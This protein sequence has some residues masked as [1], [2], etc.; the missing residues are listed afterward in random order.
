VFLVLFGTVLAGT[1]QAV[2]ITF[3]FSGA[4]TRVNP[5]LLGTFSIGQSIVGSYTFES[6]TPGQ[7]FSPGGIL[8]PSITYYPS[9]LTAYSASFGSY[10]VGLGGTGSYNRT[11]V[12]NH[13]PGSGADVYNVENVL[14]SGATVAGLV[15]GSI[16]FSFNDNTGSALSNGSL[17]QTTDD[18]SAF[19]FLAHGAL[20]FLAGGDLVRVEFLISSVSTSVAEPATLGLMALGLAGLGFVRRRRI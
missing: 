8:D 17:P 13:D 1:C 14:P 19:G 2:P 10:T 5:G 4:V 15:P 18:L 7:S 12:V 3:N 11:F 16:F 6:T 9:V 20:D